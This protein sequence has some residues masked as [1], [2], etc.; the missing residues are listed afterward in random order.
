ARCGPIVPIEDAKRFTMPGLSGT[1]TFHGVKGVRM[2]GARVLE[3]GEEEVVS[4]DGVWDLTMLGA[5]CLDV[6]H[7]YQML[8]NGPS[9]DLV[10]L[11]GP[12]VQRDAGVACR[13][14]SYFGD[15]EFFDKKNLRK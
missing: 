9:V 14:E 13:L 11:D 7:A 15:N 8:T 3:L 6:E 2:G 12:I 5:E 10:T 1:K 4:L